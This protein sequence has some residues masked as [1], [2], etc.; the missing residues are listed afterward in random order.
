MATVLLEHVCKIVTTHGLRGSASASDDFDMGF[1]R[2]VLKIRLGAPN[3]TFKLNTQTPSAKTWLMS[4]ESGPWQY[5]W[6]QRRCDCLSS[7]NGHALSHRLEKE[8]SVALDVPIYIS[9][10]QVCSSDSS[11]PV[12]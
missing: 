7:Q 5:A 6:H 8:P 1:L 10:N 11:V 9:F 2:G 12:Q 3:E 4:P